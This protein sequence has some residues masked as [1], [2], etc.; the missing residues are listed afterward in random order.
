MILAAL[1][2]LVRI[3]EE[4]DLELWLLYIKSK[5]NETDQLTREDLEEVS[6]VLAQRV[7]PAEEAA[8]AINRDDK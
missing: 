8:A 6:F 7:Q 1:L 3:V 4:G 5:A 2:L